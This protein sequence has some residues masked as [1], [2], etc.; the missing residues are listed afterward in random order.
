MS[1]PRRQQTHV[2]VADLTKRLSTAG[3]AIV[4]QHGIQGREATYFRIGN[5][6]HQTDIAIPHEFLDDLPNTKEHQAAV[7][8]YA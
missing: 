1:E 4:E 2:G 5:S 3:L 8:S 6:E 7:D